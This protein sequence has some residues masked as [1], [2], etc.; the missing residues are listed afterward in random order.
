MLK[1]DPLKLEMCKF[2]ALRCDSDKMSKRGVVE[3]VEL[4]FI[5]VTTSSD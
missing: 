2:D 1:R 4:I 5:E 3:P